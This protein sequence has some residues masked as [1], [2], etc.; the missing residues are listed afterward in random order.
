[1]AEYRDLPGF[2]SGMTDSG[3]VVDP[4][5]QKTDRNPQVFTGLTM[6]EVM[7]I[8][9]EEQAHYHA[10]QME[11]MRRSMERLVLLVSDVVPMMAKFLADSFN[12]LVPA[13]KAIWTDMEKSTDP[14]I[15]EAVRQAKARNNASRTG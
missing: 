4:A 15:V 9:H 5:M 12:A 8:V 14:A 10:V 2:G 13:V 6:D 1:M 11:E 7:Q 3:V